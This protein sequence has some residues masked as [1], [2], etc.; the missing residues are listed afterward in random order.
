[1]P[2][3]LVRII[4]TRDLVGVF[5]ADNIVQLIDIVDEWTDPDRYP[6]G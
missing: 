4:E 2:T 5:S 6:S 3:Y 1:M